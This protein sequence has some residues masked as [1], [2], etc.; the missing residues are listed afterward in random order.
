[1]KL[2]RNKIGN[3]YMIYHTAYIHT[4]IHIS[5]NINILLKCSLSLSNVFK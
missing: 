4:Y 3:D 2:L 5:I 1:M